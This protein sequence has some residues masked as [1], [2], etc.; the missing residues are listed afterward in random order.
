MIYSTYFPLRDWLHDTCMYVKHFRREVKIAKILMLKSEPQFR[1]FTELVRDCSSSNLNK[2]ERRHA[3]T[4]CP[5]NN[6]D[7]PIQ[8]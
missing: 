7:M 4:T 5:F 2:K 3:T 1:D 8:E 6:D